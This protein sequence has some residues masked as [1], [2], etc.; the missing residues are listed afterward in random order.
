MPIRIARYADFSTIPSIFAIGF[1]DE[2]VFGPFLHPYRE[3]FPQDYL[4]HWHRQCRQKF[5]DYS[6]VFLVSYETEQ[7]TGR[8]ILTGVA[9]WQRDGSGWEKVWGLWGWWD[10]RRLIQ[11]IVVFINTLANIL[12][13]NRAAAKPPQLTPYNFDAAYFP[14]VAHFYSSPPYRKNTWSL[15]C[16]AVLP[17]YR[18][19][20][21]GR[22]LV[23]WGLERARE[24]RIVANV[25]AAKGKENFYRRCGFTDLVGWATD[26]EENPL[27][28][29][30][31]EGGAILFT[32]PIREQK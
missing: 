14:Y 29:A 27:K 28:K 16:L 3:Q 10:P 17:Q 1:H 4:T 20:G 26:G 21:H 13:P 31:I 18:T 30:G 2:E 11:P 9:E 23:A 15:V 25:V 6:K 12:F 24:E 8:E 7:G 22:E 32:P 19:R 5:W